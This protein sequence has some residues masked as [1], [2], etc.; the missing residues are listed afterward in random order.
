MDRQ[1]VYPGAIP[2]DTDILSIQRNVMLALGF[3]AQGTFGTAT[4][5]F[6]L[7][8]TPT[9]PA[10]M[11]V[12]VAPGA[13]VT[14]TVVDQN[15][16]GSLAADTADGLVK[17]G[18]NLA[19]T[20]LPALTA[21][22][23]SGQS[24]NYLIEAAFSETDASP[25]VLPYYNAANPAPPYTGPG[26][27]GAAQNTQRLMR[28]Q[29]QARAGSP[30]AT[31]SQTTPAADV[32][33]VPLYVVTVAY[34]ASSITAGNISVA[35]G[36]PFIGGGSLQPGRLIGVQRFATAGTYTYTPTPGTTSVIIEIIGGGAGGGGVAA[37]GSGQVAAASGG[38]A[39][40]YVKHR[41]T[42][43]FA[44]AT[45]Y[46]APGGTGGPA[47]NNNGNPG[48]TTT[49]T[50]SGFTLSAPGGGVGLGGPAQSSSFLGIGGGPGVAGSGGNLL[51]EWGQQGGFV[52]AIV[53]GGIY[54][55][56]AGAGAPSVFGSG[57]PGLGGVTA[58]WNATSPGSGGAG[59]SNNNNGNA[60][61]AQAGGKGAD[62]MVLVWEYS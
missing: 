4:Q 13:I 56:L 60:S 5:V 36:A 47:G 62:G 14:N 45:I 43:G 16:F 46:V 7:A 9:S 3:Q 39:G 21:P 41:A 34:G 1:I 27:S 53:G 20:T 49:F 25:I 2:L 33:W 17:L 32:G 42:S 10:S 31:G 28:V 19:S 23:S 26:N 54:F 12:K 15:P 50:A 52:T 48:G 24:I 40:S 6:G 29:L 38:A 59:A 30:A 44:G 37:V 58:G 61:A 55:S 18:I 11:Q 8:C 35:S 51:N 57:A 22:A